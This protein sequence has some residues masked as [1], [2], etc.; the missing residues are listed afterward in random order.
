MKQDRTPGD[1]ISSPPQPQPHPALAGGG[2]R[3]HWRHTPSMSKQKYQH[4]CPLLPWLWNGLKGQVRRHHNGLP[5]LQ[6][7][8]LFQNRQ[9]ATM[10]L[11]G[12][13]PFLPWQHE[14][15]CCHRNNHHQKHRRAQG[16]R[17]SVCSS[18]L[19][20]VVLH[21]CLSDHLKSSRSLCRRPPG[22]SAPATRR[23]DPEP[24]LAGCFSLPPN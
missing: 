18:R 11:K 24:G 17:N 7:C 20:R 3:L 21:F 13:R 12:G 14:F 1:P 8:F 15:Y 6:A 22:P 5:Y 19:Y 4:H 16:G 2:R 9:A 10:A 23:E